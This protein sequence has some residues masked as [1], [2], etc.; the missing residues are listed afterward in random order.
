MRSLV[1]FLA[2]VHMALRSLVAFRFRSLLTA[3]GVAMGVAT[4]LSVVGIL[5]GLDRSIDGVVTEMGT[6]TL[7]VT[8]RPWI[9]IGDWWRYRTRPPVTQADAEVLE[10]RLTLANAI[11]PF[12][13]ER[14]TVEIGRTAL[15][16]VR[17]IGSN[18][19]WP[20]MAGLHPAN[21]RFL[22]YSEVR[23]ARSV[24]SVGADAANT[25]AKEGIRIG[26]FIEVAGRKMRVIGTLP[27]RG[28][29]FGRTQDD[30]VVI[31]LPLFRKLF[32][33]SRSLTIGAVADP[34]RVDLMESELVGVLRAHRRL[35][36]AEDTSFSVNGQ[37]MLVSIYEQLT[38]ALFA[39]A[40]GLGFITLIVAGVGI[41]NIMLVAVSERTQEIGIRKSLGARPSAILS[42]FL[43]EAALVS[44]VG[45]SLGTLLGLGLTKGLASITALPAAV[46][47]S[48]IVAGLAFGVIAGVLFGFLPAYFAS[49][50]EP[51]DALAGR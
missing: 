1:V 48:M 51:V 28:R 14:A 36:P 21:G 41:M 47:P 7:Y 11:V 25:M 27:E 12:V 4:V 26:D 6:G 29:I 43:A 44:G 34:D 2:S 3:L 32:G 17:V 10:E 19:A 33:Q 45:G 18:E 42:Q 40:I 15:E 50:L 39:V 37:D 9:V 5:E 38:G 20:K 35:R 49:R 13:H 22:T 24:V 8:Q 30:F 46:P 23:T 31:P 16:G